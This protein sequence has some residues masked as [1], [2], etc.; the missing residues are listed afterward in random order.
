[1]VPIFQNWPMNSG[2]C[3]VTSMAAVLTCWK[4]PKCQ[5]PPVAGFMSSSRPNPGMTDSARTRRWTLSG[6]EAAYAKATMAPMSMPTRLTKVEAEFLGEGVDVRGHVDLRVPVVWPVG[7]T[8]PAKIRRDDGESAR[9]ESGH[10]VAPDGPGVG[11]P[12]QQDNCWAFTAGHVVDPGA[13]D[14]RVGV[15]NPGI[16]CTGPCGGAMEFV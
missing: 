10:E 8:D 12:V 7:V 11:P 15:A 9:S 5:C 14:L 4:K 16:A 6:N 13:V 1:M 3:K 2:S